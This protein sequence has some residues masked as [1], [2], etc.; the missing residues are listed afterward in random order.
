M[1]RPGAPASRA[2]TRLAA[3]V[4]APVAVS[5]GLLVTSQLTGTTVLDHDALF[6]HGEVTWIGITLFLIGWQVMVA[7]MMLPASMPAIRQVAARGGTQMVAFLAGFAA[8]WTVF[9]WGA[10]GLDSTVHD[11]AAAAPR[12]ASS[13]AIAAGLLA[14]V[15]LVQ[16]APPT[17]RFVAAC[18]SW[19]AASSDGSGPGGWLRDGMR[20]GAL[21]LGCDGALMLLAFGVGKGRLAWMAGLGLIMALERTE[22]LHSALHRWIGVGALAL[23]AATLV[24]GWA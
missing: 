17:G 24:T 23:A 14:V 7:A 20:Y 5:W 1:T 16:L 2:G 21:C 8:V 6:G 9:A 3:G 18:R 22:R 15:G 4:A 19:R 10:L 11:L 12:L 13:H